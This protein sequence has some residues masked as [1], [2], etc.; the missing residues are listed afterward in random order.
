MSV[1]IVLITITNNVTIFQ[2][3]NPRDFANEIVCNNA[4]R[5]AGRVPRNRLKVSATG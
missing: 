2:N 3:P 5:A 4:S 1:K